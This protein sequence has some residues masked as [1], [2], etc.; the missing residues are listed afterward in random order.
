MKQ[1]KLAKEEV[2]CQHDEKDES[3]YCNLTG[4]NIHELS[5]IAVIKLFL[6]FNWSCVYLFARE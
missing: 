3:K 1:V 6:R 5:E 2:D 4:S